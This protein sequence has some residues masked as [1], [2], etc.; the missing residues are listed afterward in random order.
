MVL[1]NCLIIRS[2]LL[3]IDT[4]FSYLKK[5]GPM[6][7][8]CFVIAL[9]S[10]GFIR[11]MIADK[12]LLFVNSEWFNQGD[13][14]FYQDVGY[15]VFQRP[16]LMALISSIGNIM[17][18]LTVF[19]ILAYTLLY[20][21]YDFYRLKD[22]LKEKAVI[23]HVIVSVGLYFIVKAGSYKFLAEDILF[24]QGKEFTGAGFTE[25][26]VWLTYYKFAP[27]FLIAI[28]VIMIYFALKQKLKNG[29]LY[30]F[31]YPALWV[32]T[33][34][35]SVAVQALY[36]APN[37]LAVQ[38]PFIAHSINYTRQAYSLDKIITSN[39]NVNY[40]LTKNDIIRNMDTVENIRLIDYEQTLKVL[41]QNQGIRPY[42]EFKEAD[43]MTYE[44]DG[45]KTAVFLA[46]REMNKEKLDKS[47]KNYINLKMKYTHGSGVVMTP[48]N[49]VTE[50]GLPRPII[51]D[52]PCR[53]IEG[54][55]QVKQPRIYFGELTNDYVIVNTKDK[56]LDDVESAYTYDGQRY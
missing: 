14:I 17:L 5:N 29:I 53:S 40:N 55:P 35:I 16:F 38:S 7:L 23:T 8:I 15:Y 3:N 45:K 2:N 41:N 54:A 48:I 42:Y 50:E 30:I 1:I 26:E 46:A 25:V 52:I 47:A 28:A 51:K 32:I 56:E 22:I 21:R 43:I 6:L 33:V 11:N 36:V 39:K 19:N 10:S 20:A 9:M 27:Y 24:K 37:E 4:E 44:I 13:P 12:F 18:F 31:S 34:L 49:S